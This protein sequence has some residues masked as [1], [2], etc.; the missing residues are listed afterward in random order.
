MSAVYMQIALV[1]CGVWTKSGTCYKA[2]Q[3]H[4]YIA[5]KLVHYRLQVFL[6]LLLQHDCDGVHLLSKNSVPT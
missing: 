5:D 1:S 4:S 6:V 2:C 3:N